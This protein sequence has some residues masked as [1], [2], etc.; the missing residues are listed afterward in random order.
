M[1]FVADNEDGV[2]FPDLPPHVLISQYVMKDFCQRHKLVVRKRNGH[3]KRYPEWE[4]YYDRPISHYLGNVRNMLNS[5]LGERRVFNLDET[6]FIIDEDNGRAL[7]L[8]GETAVNYDEVS[9]ESDVF[10]VVPLVRGG[11]EG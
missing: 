4:A 9:N 10:T 5:G 1:Q 7:E 2:N 8:L 3:R 11:P 6:R